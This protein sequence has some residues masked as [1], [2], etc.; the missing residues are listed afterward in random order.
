MDEKVMWNAGW[1][2]NLELVQWL[3]GEGCGWC[4]ETCRFAAACGHLKVLQWL[5]ANGC[6]WD[7][8]TCKQAALYGQLET[9]R[10][11]RENGCPWNAYTRALASSKLGYT[12]DFGNLD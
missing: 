12:D 4:T 8:S 7:T 10:W 3:R 9:L 1:G 5:R 11:A 2:G 6:P